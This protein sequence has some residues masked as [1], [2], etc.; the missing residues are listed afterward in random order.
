VVTWN[1]EYADI[2]AYAVMGRLFDGSGN[3]VGGEFRVNTYTT[4]TQYG[5]PPK[6][7]ADRRGN[8]VVSWAS[9]QDG[10]SGGFGTYGV[11][12]QRFAANGT[13]RGAEFQVNTY[14]TNF[15]DMPQLDVDPA[16]N[17]VVAWRSFGQEAPATGG[18]YAR[19][20]GDLIFEDGF[21]SDVD[22]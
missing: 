3:P 6:V 9:E 11:F 12:A 7:R 16:G 17:F 21:D 20:F 13:P 14:T 2:A 19:R 4:G 5:Q 10:G 18:I 1:S 8:F 15:Q 22:P